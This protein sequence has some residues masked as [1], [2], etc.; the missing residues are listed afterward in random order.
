MFRNKIKQ[1][2]ADLDRDMEKAMS[3]TEEKA[4]VETKP[5][6]AWSKLHNDLDKVAQE[7]DLVLKQIS[8]NQLGLTTLTERLRMLN[9]K[10]I[11]F[12]I[13]TFI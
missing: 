12:W 8:D 7:K 10:N 6:E 3:M 2:I 5:N 13:I 1:L 9:E 11:E 4:E